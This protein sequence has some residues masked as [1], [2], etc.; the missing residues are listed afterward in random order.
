ML[1]LRSGCRPA[2]PAPAPY[3]VRARAR[4]RGADSSCCLPLQRHLAG[5]T[6]GWPRST[7]R[8]DQRFAQSAA[9]DRQ[10]RTAGR[11]GSR[12]PLRGASSDLHRMQKRPL[13]VDRL[14]EQ[15]AI[16]EPS[17]R[18]CP[19]GAVV[20]DPRLRSLV[21]CPFHDSSSLSCVNYADTLSR[22]QS[23]NSEQRASPLRYRKT[24]SDRSAA[25]S[26]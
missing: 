20:D 6:P 23:G 17:D 2:V 4:Y 21:D 25:A 5:P 8:F 24:S 18:P 15:I 14:R 16:A 19:C 1:Q 10:A 7:S 26:L 13:R 22:C 11:D 3:R 12:R 9:S